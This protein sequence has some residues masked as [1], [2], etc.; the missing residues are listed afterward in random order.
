LNVSKNML[1]SNDMK[2]KTPQETGF[3]ALALDLDGT[4]LNEKHELSERNCQAVRQMADLGYEIILATGRSYEALNKFK[5]QL[6]LSSL[7][8]CYNGACIM[9]GKNNAV[10]IEHCLDED[11]ARFQVKLARQNKIHFHSFMDTQLLF[12]QKSPESDEYHQRSG[13]IGKIVNFDDF[14]ELRL[15]KAMYIGPYEKLLKIKE[16]LAEQFGDRIYQAFSNPQYLEVMAGHVS[17]AN[18]LL[19]VFKTLGIDARN[20]MAFGDGFNDLEMLLECGHGVAMGNASEEIRNNAQLHNALG[21]TE[22]G[23]AVYLE[24]YFS[25]S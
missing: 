10:V 6:E 20:T 3:R 13:L 7:V 1:V 17:K 16:T 25:L 4:L 12:E 15:T 2:G 23:V 18:T 5:M 14:P 21:N 8:V 22:D 9:D 19:E 11:I 24:E